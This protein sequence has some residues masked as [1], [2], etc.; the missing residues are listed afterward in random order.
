MKVIVLVIVLALSP[1]N[2]VVQFVTPNWTVCQAARMAMPS[3]V[4]IQVNGV[5][6]RAN[7]LRTKCER[8]DDSM[9]EKNKKILM[10][11]IK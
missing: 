3:V 4:E 11:D 1:D 6:H 7:V 10:G 5:D 2:V 8:M 9:V